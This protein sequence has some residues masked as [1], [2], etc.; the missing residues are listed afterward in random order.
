MESCHHDDPT[1]QGAVSMTYSSVSRRVAASSLGGCAALA[2]AL[3]GCHTPTPSLHLELS[4]GDSQACPSTACENVAL[5]C[6]AVMSIQIV[7]PDD[8]ARPYLSQCEEVPFD[9]DRT[10]CSLSRVALDATALPV[11]DL[12]V[13]VAVFPMTMAT[14]DPNQPSG[15]RCPSNVRY[16]AATGYPIEQFPSPALGG[17]AFYHPGDSTVV[18][19]LGCTDL[20]LLAESCAVASP[21]KV[22]ATVEDFENL[23]PVPS[24]PAANQ[25]RVSVG[26]PR[27]TDGGFVFTAEESRPLSPVRESEGTAIWS[28]ELDVQFAE[29]VC[30]E[31]L[32]TVAQTTAT[33]RCAP[34]G[35]NGEVGELRGVR[36]SKATLQT[37]LGATSALAPSVI[38]VPEDGITVGIV[39]DQASTPIEG[40]VVRSESAIKYLSKEGVLVDDGGTSKRGVFVSTTAPFG[41]RFATSGGSRGEISALGG[42]VAGRVTVVVLQYGG[43]SL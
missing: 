35:P 17:Q 34:V 16:S 2:L 21:V 40:M 1:E 5:P 12:E 18:V 36:I 20:A 11:R 28:D 42:R 39:V 23:F 43:P 37:V 13:Q 9:N 32:E 19:K 27:L 10:M 25:L 38:E 6:R 26:E 22:S 4:S 14:P 3:A 15:L 41:T 33:L 7:D 8:R 30:V 31:V 29:H 24:G